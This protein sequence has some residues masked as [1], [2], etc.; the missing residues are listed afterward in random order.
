MRYAGAEVTALL[1]RFWPYIT[2]ALV[3]VAA[4]GAI[5]VLNAQKTA[6]RAERDLARVELVGMTAAVEAERLSVHAATDA[7]ERCAANASADAARCTGALFSARGEADRYRAQ[8]RSCVSPAA[9]A[10]RLRMV[11]P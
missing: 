7:S 9:V 6:A 1:A 3:A 11:F 2:G 4:A 5:V 10:Q 8:L